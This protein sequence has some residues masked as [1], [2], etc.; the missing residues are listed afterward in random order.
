M[1]VANGYHE[2]RDPQVH[3]SR[4][5]ADQQRRQALNLPAYQIDSRFMAAVESG[6]PDTSGVA[7]GVDRLLMA[8]SGK[9]ISGVVIFP[10]N[11]A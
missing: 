9:P 6:L 11:L 3:L 8:L 1:E 5:L 4:F 2:L 7:L 10:A